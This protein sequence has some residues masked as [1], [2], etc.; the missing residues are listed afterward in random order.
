MPA[1][2][3]TYAAIGLVAVLATVVIS[4]WP[5][6]DHSQDVPVGDPPIEAQQ[7]DDPTSVIPIIDESGAGRVETDDE[8]P[9]EVV[10]SVYDVDRTS[11]D[12]AIAAAEATM[13]LR[14]AEH[15]DGWIRWQPIMID[16]H[17]LTNDAYLDGHAVQ[18]EF[19][20]SPFP[21]RSYKASMTDYRAR[22]ATASATWSGVL[23]DGESGTLKI[24]IIG[25]PAGSQL[26]FHFRTIHGHF[27]IYP[28]DV[29]G[30]YVASEPNEVYWRDKLVSN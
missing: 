9:R 16:A 23:D 21:D 15:P 26:I 5:N 7:S 28:T 14:Q 11:R 30:A 12:R 19:Q 8:V 10:R 4:L 17:E 1:Q 18:K 20:I 25:T 3:G 2:R 27:N 13:A 6:V 29:Y 22:R 24:T